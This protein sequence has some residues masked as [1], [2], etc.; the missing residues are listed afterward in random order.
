ME[1]TSIDKELYEIQNIKNIESITMNDLIDNTKGLIVPGFII[2]YDDGKYLAYYANE[3]Y[4]NDFVRKITEVYN[5]EKNNILETSLS[6]PFEIVHGITIDEKAKKVL[7]NGL[8]PN[9]NSLYNFYL[10][11]DSYNQSLLFQKDIVKSNIDIITYVLN[12]LFNVLNL[13]VKFDNK[14]NGYKDNYVITGEINK[15]ISEFPFA[16]E[17]VDENTYLYEFG[18]IFSDTSSLL[19]TLKF[20]KD[21]IEINY[22]IPNANIFG[23]SEYRIT[24]KVVKEIIDIKHNGLSVMYRNNDLKNKNPEYMNLVKLDSDEEFS[25]FSMPWNAYIG[26]KTSVENISDLEKNVDIHHMYLSVNSNNFL[27]REIYSR[28]YSQLKSKGLLFN[29]FLLDA[30]SK[31]ITGIFNDTFGYLIETNFMDSG[32]SSSHYESELENKYF[33]HLSEV[34][35]INELSQ[36]NLIEITKKDGITKNTDLLQPVKMIKLLRRDK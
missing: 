4:F 34:K 26:I 16:Y 29:S 30:F 25:W 1:L 27:I 11:K 9:I 18:G 13:D 33:Y 22:S 35:N 8:L 14:I 5:D 17:E 12:N 23:T 2:V 7:E 15:V 3:K 19:L 36:N 6:N 24:N 21:K 20:L 31:K 32:N 28:T 10:N